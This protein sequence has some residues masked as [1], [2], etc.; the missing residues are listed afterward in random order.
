MNRTEQLREFNRCFESFGYLVVN[1]VQIEDAVLGEWIPFALWPEQEALA[2]TLFDNL[3]VVALKARQLGLTWLVLAFAL[4]LMLFRPAATILLFSRR[5]TEAIHLLDDRLK[6][7]YRRLPNWLKVGQTVVEDSAHE[8]QLSNG[9]VARAFP[10]SAGDSY[11]AT[12]AIVDEADLVPDLN[13]LMRAV[14]PTIDGG[15]RM[16]LLSRSDKRRPASTFKKIY[17]GGKAGKSDWVSVFLPWYIRPERDEEWYEAQKRDILS[18]TGGLD[19]LYEQYPATDDEA[20]SPA[21]LDKRLPF[22][23]IKKCFDEMAPITAEGFVESAVTV[24]QLRI[25]RRPVVGHNYVIGADPAE[26]NP[27]SDDSAL[28]VIDIGN[29]EE[30]ASLA[31]KLQ[32]STFAS[33]ISKVSQ[34][35]NLAPALVERN[36]HGHAVILW[37]QS[38]APNVALLSGMDGRPGWLTSSVSK[39]KLF[40]D[41]GD[42]LRF[43]EAVIHGLDT[44]LQLASIDGSTLSAP[45]GQLD[46][47][48][49]SFALAQQARVIPRV[50]TRVSYEP[51]RIVSW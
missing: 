10:T 20:L 15:G 11:T 24:A 5:D 4:W 36:N 16:I 21:M 32:P 8:W 45:E 22:I 23:W 13:R 14:K 26:G 42:V 44:Y 47:L 19:D 25:Y 37:L 7:M 18:R 12:L 51:V 1:Y 35:Y 30:V 31:A 29:G 17:R 9:S 33:A 28:S 6:G 2:R 48:A 43:D 27:T 34:F 50:E 46:D 40:D 49:I 38:F 39:V 3:L 41:L